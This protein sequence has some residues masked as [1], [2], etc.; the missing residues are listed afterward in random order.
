MLDRLRER[1]VSIGITDNDRRHM[2]A[3]PVARRL[4]LMRRL[5]SGPP[6]EERHFLGSTNYV[7]AMLKLRAGGL[8]LIDLQWQETSFTAV[9][10][11]RSA[12]VMGLLMS[13][14]M[15]LVVWEINED[16]EEVTTVR[17]WRT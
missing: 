7:K 4:T 11:R 16:N 8:R 9:W 5:M 14:A 1:S 13:E 2:D 12:S 6:T 15:A 17:T 10:Y 3:I